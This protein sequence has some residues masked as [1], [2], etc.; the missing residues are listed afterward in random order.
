MASILGPVAPPVPISALPTDT[1]A[2][3]TDIFP[4]VQ[5]GVTVQENWL[6]VYKLFLSNFVL[7]YPGDPNGNVAGTTY[8]LLWD[9]L[10]MVLYVCTTTG[11]ATTAV[12]TLAGGANSAFV[13]NDVSMNAVTMLTDNGYII[14]SPGLCTLTLPLVSVIGTE[15][16]IIGR[17]LNGWTIAQNAGQTIKIGVGKSTTGVAGSI[18]STQPEDSIYL[19]C[20]A[21]NTEWTVCGG[22]EGNLTIV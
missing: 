1:V 15:L 5:A 9:T 18:A 10:G 13:W 7:N 16:K 17:G 21:P 19:V 11:S 22:P 14:D 8:Q 3:F 12:W 4:V 20:T 6:Q 2:Q